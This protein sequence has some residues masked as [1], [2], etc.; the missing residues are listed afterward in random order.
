[1]I[2]G[3]GLIL[4]TCYRQWK[5]AKLKQ[6]LANYKGVQIRIRMKMLG[7]KKELEKITMK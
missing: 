1:M 5:S 7:F 6:T 2:G 3:E 4:I